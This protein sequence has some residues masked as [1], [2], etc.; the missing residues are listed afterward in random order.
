MLNI[1]KRIIK[2]THI[3]D[4][5]VLAFH[6]QVIKVSPKSDIA[7]IWVDTCDLQ[8]GIKAKC[9]I[10]KCFN[11]SCHIMTVRRTKMNSGVL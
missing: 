6:L 5:M 2:S 10:N 11:V 7:I 8:N 9:L 1:I 3:F 4:D